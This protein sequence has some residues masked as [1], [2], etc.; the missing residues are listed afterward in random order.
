MLD[1][2]ADYKSPCEQLEKV[3]EL[4]IWHTFPI[5]LI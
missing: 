3:I 4:L 5:Y 1:I 2:I